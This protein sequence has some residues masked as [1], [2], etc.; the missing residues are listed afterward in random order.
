MKP[1][2]TGIAFKNNKLYCFD[3]YG[4]TVMSAWPDIKAYRKTRTR[5]WRCLRPKFSLNEFMQTKA[6]YHSDA[7][8]DKEIEADSVYR[9]GALIPNDVVLAV[10]SYPNRHW[11]L[12]ALVARCGSPALDLI[13]S[14]PALAWMLASSWIFKEKPVRDHFRSIRNLFNKSRSQ[15]QILRWL[16][17]PASKS[18]LKILRK[19]DIDDID[20]TILLNL[21]VLLTNQS[22][23]STLR[24]LKV[25]NK[26][27]IWL[28]TLNLNHDLNLSDAFLL[29][30]VKPNSWHQREKANDI[31]H[32]AIHVKSELGITIPSIHSLA[33]LE[34]ITEDAFT[35]RLMD[36]YYAKKLRA[37]PDTVF[38]WFPISLPDSFPQFEF[39]DTRHRLIR[40]A[41]LQQHCAESYLEEVI[42]GNVFFFAVYGNKRLTLSLTWDNENYCWSIDDF[43]G[44]RNTKPNQEDKKLVL[45]WLAEIDVL[46]R[47]YI[48]TEQSSFG[49]KKLPNQ[50][51]FQ[52]YP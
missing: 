4:V 26:W 1:F 42:S 12:L 31:I 50:P 14:T 33:Q 51:C 3:R 25:I 38:P 20:A 52:F 43:A 5:P 30:F 16:N 7:G 46:T 10:N 18:I 9:W 8:I 2:V 32:R 34:Q 45:S 22:T 35:S 41:N 49:V 17:Y 6:L 11:H 37:L 39:I 27:N 21:R 48:K 28:L 23:A 19:I 44:F 24:H 29:H 15:V 47:E 13:Q 36:E 40:E